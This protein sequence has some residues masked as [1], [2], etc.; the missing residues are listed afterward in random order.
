MKTVGTLL[1]KNYVEKTLPDCPECIA[2]KKKTI[3][4]QQANSG[5]SEVPEIQFPVEGEF[6]MKMDPSTKNFICKKCGLY[7]TREQVND[8]RDRL[9]QREV[10]REDKQYDYL[11]WWQKSKKDKQ[12]RQS[13]R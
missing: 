8:I 9:N 11:D 10:T 7:A 3:I 6:P 2:R 1:W 5:E 4:A 12:Q 13:N